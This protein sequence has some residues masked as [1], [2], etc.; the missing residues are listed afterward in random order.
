[1]SQKFDCFVI[2]KSFTLLLTLLLFDPFFFGTFLRLDLKLPFLGSLTIQEGG[3]IILLCTPER[4]KF[5]NVHTIEL[6]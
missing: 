2:I 1:M 4:N 6:T 3:T 5:I